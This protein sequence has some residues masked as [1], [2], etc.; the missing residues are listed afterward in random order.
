MKPATKFIFP[1]S[2]L[3]LTI[4][5]E[6]SPVSAQGRLYPLVAGDVTI[7]GY[8]GD[9]IYACITNQIQRLSVPMLIAPFQSRTETRFWQTEF[10]GKWATAACAAYRYTNNKELLNKLITAADSLVATQTPDGYIGNY[11]QDRRLQEWDIWGRKYCLLGLLDIY[12]IT[13]NKELLA[14]AQKSADHLITEIGNR[15]ISDFGNFRGMASSSILE[16]VVRLYTYT[17]KRQYLAFAES[18]VTG[19][20]KGN[21][22]RLI[23][24]SLDNVPVAN[25]FEKPLK[26]FGPENGQKAYEMM[27]CYEGLLEL[28]K[29][30]RNETYKIAVEKAARNIMESEIMV[31]GTGSSLEC[32]YNGRNNQAVPA[33]SMNETCVTATWLKLC[34]KLL[35]LTG[36]PRY[37]DNIEQTFYNALLGSMTPDGSAWSKYSELNGYRHFG[38]MQCG[39][40]L[41]C[42]IASGPRGMMIIPQMAV[43][44]DSAGPVINFFGSMKATVNMDRSRIAI[45]QESAYPKSNIVEITVDPEKSFV[46]EVKIRIPSWSDSAVL[47]INGDTLQKP[48]AASY[49]IIKRNW[50]KGDKIK[51]LLD[52]YGRMSETQDKKAFAFL[53]GP[54][55]LA[56]DERTTSYAKFNY[57]EP[58]VASTGRV[59][60]IITEP[61]DK[62]IFFAAKVPVVTA[63]QRGE[64]Y[65]IDYASAGNTWDQSSGYMTWLPKLLDLR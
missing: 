61:A 50:R 33:R 7:G 39:M 38:E 44:K 51:L 22:A 64:L 43:M 5:S 17:G 29:I 23:S 12:D 27:S 62:S 11:R 55:V 32:W 34:N 46:F 16:P 25:R 48:S 63:G 4:V 1:L 31:T 6:S 10:W 15:N 21:G 2:F 30:T 40:P 35:Q 42:C 49:A 45:T 54:L 36:D 18:I 24:K 47:M 19:W 52:M 20:E 3:L 28:Y 9:K 8:T 26:W 60:Y 41:N 14:A 13:R 57:Y 65:M 37:A 58:V 53:Y 56:A 59:K